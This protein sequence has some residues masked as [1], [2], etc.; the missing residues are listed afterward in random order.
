[1]F[2]YTA[3]I[4]E[5]PPFDTA[6]GSHSPTLEI[7]AIKMTPTTDFAIFSRDENMQCWVTIV[8]RRRFEEEVFTSYTAFKSTR[9]WKDAKEMSEQE[10]RDLLRMMRR[11]DRAP[12][13]QGCMDP[14]LLMQPSQLSCEDGLDDQSNDDVDALVAQYREQGT[15]KVDGESYDQSSSTSVLA[16]EDGM[17]TETDSSSDASSSVTVVPRRTNALSNVSS[18][19]NGA[20]VQPLA[21]ED[22]DHESDSD[23][24]TTIVDVHPEV[25][26]RK[27]KSTPDSDA[28][29]SKPKKAKILSN[30]NAPSK[31]RCTWASTSGSTS[32]SRA[33]SPDDDVGN[34][35]SD[36]EGIDEEYRP[37]KK[38]SNRAR[39]KRPSG[40]LFPNR[41][42]PPGVDGKVWKKFAWRNKNKALEEVYK[43]TKDDQE[44]GE[45]VI[46]GTELDDEEDT[47]Y[48]DLSGLKCGN[49]GKVQAP[50][51]GSLRT[52]KRHLRT[53]KPNKEVYP[54]RGGYSEY[55]PCSRAQ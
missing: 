36:D 52:F 40:K 2:Y 53:H 13:T 55:D 17:E 22:S 33:P 9:W 31:A 32:R 18:W 47:K 12:E 24:H 7:T 3:A 15:V 25:R 54:C 6:T 5:C 51:N 43:A 49:C 34:E 27:R 28:S 11:Q 45:N 14:R 50:T 44:E 20:N 37:T 23:E 4:K 42:V 48:N 8:K 10:Y 46:F 39:S 35:D 29:A 30:S 1:M 41:S 16:S 26:S 38:N 19:L 21:D